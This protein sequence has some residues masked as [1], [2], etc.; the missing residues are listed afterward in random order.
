M[1][2]HSSHSIG[3][4]SE[5]ERGFSSFYFSP[6]EYPNDY[7]VL[8]NE[9]IKNSWFFTERTLLLSALICVAIFIS[10]ATPPA[11]TQKSVYNYVHENARNVNSN[12]RYFIWALVLSLAPLNLLVILVQMSF[13]GIYTTCNDDCRSYYKDV[14]SYYYIR[15]VMFSLF[16]AVDLLITL[17]YCFVCEKDCLKGDFPLAKATIPTLG[18]RSWVSVGL[19]ALGIVTI[20]ISLKLLIFHAVYI[21]LGFI[22]SPIQVLSIGTLYA[23]GVFCVIVYSAVWLKF[24]SCTCDDSG[25]LTCL[26]GFFKNI[27]LPFITGVLFLG[28]VALIIVFIYRTIVA[29]EDYRNSGGVTTFITSLAPTALLGVI[30]YTGKRLISLQSTN[31]NGNNP[32]A[33]PDVQPAG[34]VVVDLGGGGNNQPLAV[35][36]QPAVL[37]RPDVAGG[38]EL[39][40][41]DAANAA[42]QRDHEERPLLG[43]S[44]SARSYGS[45][46]TT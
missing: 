40:T 14:T 37:A 35:T 6:V 29:S 44:S 3:M 21:L 7:C 31:G 20:Q 33:P 32:V 10:L 1:H 38:D 41:A 27:L 46:D 15:L 30:G 23:A 19:Q 8:P 12:W 16:P 39:I 26:N 11:L 24:C 22:A 25:T 43:G 18:S 4:L 17:V 5:D 36:Q 9:I 42:A 13:D 2:R 34:H 45:A 28:F